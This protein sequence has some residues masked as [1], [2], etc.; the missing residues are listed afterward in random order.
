MIQIPKLYKTWGIYKIENLINKKVYI[1]SSSIL[2]Y[3]L[4][5]HFN[6]LKKNCHSNRHLQ[7]AWNKYGEENF[8]LEILEITPNNLETLLNREDYYLNKYQSFNK[9]KGYNIFD[10]ASST[11]GCKWSKEAKLRIIGRG[12]GRKNSQ[13]TKDKISKSHIGIRHSLDSIQKMIRSR[14]IPII[15]LDL[16]G[17]FIK[18]WDSAKTASLWLGITPSTHI[19]NVLNG[20]LKTC[21]GYNFVRKS[22]YDKE[23]NYEV[24]KGKR[25]CVLQFSLDNKLIRQFD[26]LQEAADFVKSSTTN[27]SKCCKGIRKTCNKF[28]WKYKI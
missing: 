21:K 15:M 8:I 12:K 9:D 23:K 20:K 3:R 19:S 11:K 6:N 25:I 18:E 2:Y 28:I 14:K 1:G 4:Y 5:T 17:N 16:K 7:S 10:K 24:L 26:S 22:E 27:I 13:E